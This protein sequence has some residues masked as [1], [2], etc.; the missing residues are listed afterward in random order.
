MLSELSDLTRK[1]NALEKKYDD[2][3]SMVFEAIHQLMD[4]P[5]PSAY[6]RRRIVFTKDI[7]V[8]KDKK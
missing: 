4:E 7:K 2:N 8:T 1:L 6:S 3:F 5:S